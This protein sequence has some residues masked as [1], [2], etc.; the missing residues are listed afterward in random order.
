[1]RPFLYD[2]L[3]STIATRAPIRVS[4]RSHGCYPRCNRHFVASIS[5]PLKSLQGELTDKKERGRERLAVGWKTHTHNSATGQ[6]AHARSNGG[7]AHAKRT[8]RAASKPSECH[9]PGT[10]A[11]IGVGMSLLRSG[12][13]VAKPPAS[14]SPKLNP[15]PLPSTCCETIKSIPVH[16]SRERKRYSFPHN[17]K[18]SNTRGGGGGAQQK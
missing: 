8:P 15:S 11:M 3:H 6:P 10:V 9:S 12:C 1:M 13:A 18:E 2:S 14:D 4:L 17:A 7:L 5:P 16:N